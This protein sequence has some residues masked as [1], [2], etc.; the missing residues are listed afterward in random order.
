MRELLRAVIDRFAPQ[1]E[2]AKISLEMEST[3]PQQINGDQDRLTQVFNNLLENA[4]KFTPSAGKIRI[5]IQEIKGFLQIS[6]TDS[7]SGISEDEI[8]RIFERFYQADKSRRAGRARGVG[9]G[10]PIAKQI[11]EAHHGSISVESLTERGTRF[12]VSLPLGSN[13]A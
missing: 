10:L 13:Q 4:L 3:E 9:L 2:S 11:V 1:A 6:V 12:L 8:D 5:E 7:G